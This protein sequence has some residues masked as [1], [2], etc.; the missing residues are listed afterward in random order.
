LQ[1]F[2]D[3]T[4][5]TD[6]QRISQTNNDDQ[7]YCPESVAVDDDCTNVDTIL[8]NDPVFRDTNWVLSAA[9]ARISRNFSIHEKTFCKSKW[10]IMGSHDKIYITRFEYHYQKP[11]VQAIIAIM[12]GIFHRL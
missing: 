9:T 8:S 11:E 7:H 10:Y 5:S 4:S 12:V 1:A 6:T 3:G 2:L